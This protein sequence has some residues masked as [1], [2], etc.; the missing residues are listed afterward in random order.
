MLNTLDRTSA[1]KL[2]WFATVIHHA[3]LR[4]KRKYRRWQRDVLILN[5]VSDTT[6]AEF[7]DSFESPTAEIEF[8]NAEFEQMFMSLPLI[9]WKVMFDLYVRDFTQQQTAKDVQVSQQQVSRIRFAPSLHFV[10][11]WVLDEL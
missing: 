2:S 11:K 10:R 5:Q 7:V 6:G 8:Q 1:Q 4:S 3:A 9:Q